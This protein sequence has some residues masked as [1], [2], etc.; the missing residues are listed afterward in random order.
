M[1]KVVKAKENQ[2]TVKAHSAN[3][4][5]KVFT[6]PAESCCDFWELIRSAEVISR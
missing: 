3:Q 2:E 6:K 1:E 4:R 5:E